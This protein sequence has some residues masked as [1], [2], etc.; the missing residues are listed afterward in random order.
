[1]SQ[2]SFKAEIGKDDALKLQALY[3][4]AFEDEGFPISSF[5]NL[6]EPEFW[7][8]AIYVDNSIADDIH[9]QL[10][11]LANSENIQVE[12]NREEIS[13][14]DWVAKTLRDLAPVRAGRFIVHGSHDRHEPKDHEFAIEV[15]A[16]LAFGTGHHGTTAGCLEMLD[17]VLKAKTFY[18]ALDLGTGSGVLAIAIAKAIEAK[19]LATDIDPV[20]TITAR[21]NVHKNGTQAKV[22]CLTSAGFSD[23]RTS[24][25]APFDLVIA[26]ILA[27]PLQAMALD[28]C[29]HT[30][31]GGTVILSGLLPHQRA[32]LV[33]R[34]RLHGLH[35]K[36]SHIRD[37]WLVLV[38][39]K[40]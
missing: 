8:I 6:D 11:A 31:Q 38:F 29:L 15:D 25:S 18:N 34:F 33:A 14:T 4:N 36:Y 28:I 22:K 21:D 19:V 7:E 26:N 30:A 32:P 40:P 13:D 39:D 37:G 10:L 24:Q 3:E 27:R 9:T 17:R 35:L 20:S 16:G 2:T 23:Y 5:E 1:M 12:F